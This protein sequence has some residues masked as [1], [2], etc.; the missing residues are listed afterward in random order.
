[1]YPTHGE[2]ACLSPPRLLNSFCTKL[3]WHRQG[4]RAPLSA[5]SIHGQ[6]QQQKNALNYSSQFEIEILVL[7]VKHFLLVIDVQIDEHLFQNVHQIIDDL[8]ILKHQLSRG[9]WFQETLGLSE[10]G[11]G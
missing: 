4:S 8:Q 9:D 2:S 6:A 11:K 10:P 7:D 5:S 1:M 3:K